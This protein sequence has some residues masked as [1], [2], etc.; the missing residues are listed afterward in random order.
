MNSLREWNLLR[1]GTT[2]APRVRTD[3]VFLCAQTLRRTWARHLAVLKHTDRFDDGFFFITEHR[4]FNVQSLTLNRSLRIS[5]R[6]FQV[7]DAEDGA[8]GVV[9]RAFRFPSRRE[10]NLL[11][12]RQTETGAFFYGW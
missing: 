7:G 5:R 10:D 3:S 8:L 12:H 1:V 11:D 2:R 4:T 9:R 6:E